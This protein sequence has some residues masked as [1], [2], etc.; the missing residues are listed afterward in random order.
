MEKKARILFIHPP[1]TT[2]LKIQKGLRYPPL[3]IA[4][5][6]AVV[7]KSGAEVRIFDGNVER[8]PFRV[9][10]KLL[11]EYAP[12][13][14]GISFTSMLAESA[15]Y[16]AELI[17]K[18]YPR[19]TVIAGGYHPTV[20]PLDVMKDDN[21]DFVVTGEGERT[22]TEWLEQYESKNPDYGQ[23]K[24]LLFRKEGEVIQTPQRELIPDIDSLPFPAYDLLPIGRYSS[25]VSTR[26]PYVT[27]IRSRGCPFRCTFCGVQRMF[28]HR[29]RCNS[30]ERT[31]SDI[32]TL[33]R[34]FGVKEILF[35]DSDFL[36]D[37]KNV[38]R[39]CE[40]LI[41]RK[42]DLIWSCNARVDVVNEKVLGLMKKAGCKMITYGVE[43]GNQEI[44]NRLKKGITPDQA[45][46]AVRLTKKAGIQTTV[47]LIFGGPGETRGTIG[48]TLRFIKLLDPDYG[49]FAY[50]T[51]FPGSALYDEALRN[52]WFIDGKPNS[53]GYESLRL[54]A[55]GMSSKELAGALKHATRYFY[56]RP[57]Y[58]LKRLRHMTFTDFKNNLKGLCAILR[59]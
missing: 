21:F 30:P 43:S 25:L 59:S 57:E 47:N 56:L 24:G 6:S 34:D 45:I 14:A 42:Y 11:K 29:Y 38:E 1:A 54:N 49:N 36:I 40:L 46:N 8:N 39:L 51:A 5:L 4:F 3:G 15:H 41:E 12:D 16:T 55:T 17:K 9:L 44:L 37:I 19:I 22:F 35:K 52:N 27:F 53:F 20:M 10:Q 32:D 31:I 26:N 50:L 33:V 18:A 48:E 13:V 7:R 28:G 58:I 23:V 2:G